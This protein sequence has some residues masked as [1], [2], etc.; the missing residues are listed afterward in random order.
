MRGSLRLNHIVDDLLEAARLE[1]KSLYMAREAINPLPMVRDLL[2]DFRPMGESRKLRIELLDFPDDGMIRGDVHHLKRALGR[3]MENAIKFTPEGGWVRIAGRTL[4]Q[5]EV[6]ALTEK[7]R[8]FSESFF[9]GV[10]K[11]SYLQ[12]SISDSGIGID[13]DDQVRIFDK[14]HEVGDISGH[15]TSK[16]RFGGKGV[17]LGLTLAKGIIETHEGLVWVDSAG[18]A[19]G[20][21]FSTLLPLASPGEGRYVLG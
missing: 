17:G 19:Q 14:F 1:A 8:A 11:E 6:V 7:L 10:L 5:E 20:S 18:P 4:Q 2:A 12:I 13:K 9:E 21:C 16:A 15:S 3:L